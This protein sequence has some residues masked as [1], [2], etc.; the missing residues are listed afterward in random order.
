METPVLTF[1]LVEGD[2]YFDRSKDVSIDSYYI[3]ILGGYFEVGTEEEPFER[4][5]VITLHGDRYNSIEIPMIGSKTLAVAARGVP[6]AEH[7][8]GEHLTGRDQGQLE[9]HGM[10][11]LR[12]WTKLNETARAGQSWI[13][14][15]EPV[16]FKGGETVILTG[17]EL[18]GTFDNYGM[19]LLLVASTID[20]HNVSFTQNLKYNHRSEIVTIEGRVIDM[21]CEIGLLS[22]NIIIQGD[23]EK[24]DGQLF[25]IHTL[26]AHSGIYRME[27][28]EIRRCG[29]AFNFGRYCTHSHKAGDMRGSYVKANSIHHSYQR[30]VT[31]HDTHNW[32]VSNFQ[33]YISK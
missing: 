16:D 24:S 7:D 13:I 10:K 20:G 33:F 17:S 9:V 19:E 12:T 32:E 27:N 11:R 6:M 3:F 5:A 30:A 26:A 4:N 28:A 1:L 18:P 14:T 21:R 23:E 2:L 22:R 25:G 31:T 29:Q 15:A 8:T